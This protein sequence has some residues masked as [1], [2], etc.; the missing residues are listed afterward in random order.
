MVPGF[1][2]PQKSKDIPNFWR[3]ENSRMF[4]VFGDPNSPQKF[5]A[6]PSF[7]PQKFKDIPSFWNKRMRSQFPVDSRGLEFRICRFRRFFGRIFL[8]FFKNFQTTEKKTLK[9]LG[10]TVLVFPW[11]SLSWVDIFWN[12]LY[13]TCTIIPVFI[14]GNLTSFVPIF[15][16]FQEDKKSPDLTPTKCFGI[17]LP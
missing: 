1:G 17:V 4:P 2:E 13:L 10:F 8:A 5:K 11:N 9:K 12:F 6:S 14:G 3:V 7:W 15:F 16:F